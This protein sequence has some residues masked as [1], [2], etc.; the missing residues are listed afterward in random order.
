MYSDDL[1]P[2]VPGGSR[3]FDEVP[4][5]ASPAAARPWRAPRDRRPRRPFPLSSTA[6]DRGSGSGSRRSLPTALRSVT[7][8]RT[9]RERA[10]ARF[11]APTVLRL[12]SREIA[13]SVRRA[14]D[15]QRAASRALRTGDAAAARVLYATAV[16][17]AVRATLLATGVRAARGHPI[18]VLRRVRSVPLVPAGKVFRWRRA[19]N[20]VEH[21]RFPERFPTSWAALDAGR[22]IAVAAIVL[23]RVVRSLAVVGRSPSGATATQVAR[24]VGVDALELRRVLERYARAGRLRRRRGAYVLPPGLLRARLSSL[25]RGGRAG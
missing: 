19:A 6:R 16:R 13:V 17:E 5:P 10:A 22:T 20:A 3:V 11:P 14:N 23:V 21:G 8:P 1:A 4:S 12:L 9:R 15:A 18:A 25:R 7:G 24:E 2:H